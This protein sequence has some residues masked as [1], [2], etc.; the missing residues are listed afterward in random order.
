MIPKEK[1][2][3]TLTATSTENKDFEGDGEEEGGIDVNSFIDHWL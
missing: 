1:R 3:C 2:T